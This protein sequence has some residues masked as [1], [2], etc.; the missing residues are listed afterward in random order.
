[1]LYAMNFNIPPCYNWLGDRPTNDI[2]I[3]FKIW[4]KYAVLWLKI[5]FTDHNKILH[6]SRQCNCRDV[7]KI[8]L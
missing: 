8:S 6:T 1:M 3:Q 7:C 5:Y 4:T 2:S